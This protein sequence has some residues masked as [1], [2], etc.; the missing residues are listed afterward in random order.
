MVE[1]VANDAHD[2]VFL[3]SSQVL[4]MP[5]S[6]LLMSSIQK[7]R[8]KSDAHLPDICMPRASHIVATGVVHPHLCQCSRFQNGDS[9]VT[10]DIGRYR[11]ESSYMSPGRTSMVPPMWTPRQY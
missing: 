5:P 9:T 2:P 4:N 7:E 10:P 1:S 6:E 11:V 8:G 3:A